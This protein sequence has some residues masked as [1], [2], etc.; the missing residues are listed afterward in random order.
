MSLEELKA[1]IADLV[2]AARLNQLDVADMLDDLA[3]DQRREVG[4]G[5]TA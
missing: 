5:E 2:Q 1:R 4:G 3:K